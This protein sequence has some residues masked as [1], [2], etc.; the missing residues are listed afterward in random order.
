MLVDLA[1]GVP[2]PVELAGELGCDA[3]LYCTGWIGGLAVPI[4]AICALG[5]V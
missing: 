3:I 4:T 5:G 1:L 2:A